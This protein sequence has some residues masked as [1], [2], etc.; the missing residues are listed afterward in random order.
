MCQFPKPLSGESS[1]WMLMNDR[2]LCLETGSLFQTLES[3]SGSAQ[4]AVLSHSPEEA[5]L[6]PR[7]WKK[8][9][10][11]DYTGS[12]NRMEPWGWRAKPG[13]GHW[14]QGSQTSRLMEIGRI[15]CAPST[16]CSLIPGEERSG[17]AFVV[18][19][20]KAGDSPADGKGWSWG[21]AIGRLAL[22]SDG[23]PF[24]WCLMNTLCFLTLTFCLA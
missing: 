22:L 21:W 1:V 6:F 24:P 23:S 10:L 11:W 7:A 13:R 15:C 20:D 18:T 19:A 4:T 5:P 16:P 2:I 12:A 17:P 9:K 3:Q 14:G 8:P